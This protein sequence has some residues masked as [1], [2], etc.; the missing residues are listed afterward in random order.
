MK[1]LETTPL[2]TLLSCSDFFPFAPNAVN[3]VANMPSYGSSSFLNLWLS[4][5]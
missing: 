5:S 4:V 1:S 2:T 3:F